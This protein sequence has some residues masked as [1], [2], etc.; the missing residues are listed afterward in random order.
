MAPASQALTAALDEVTFRPAHAPV[1]A[2]VDA[3]L[4]TDGHDWSALCARQLVSPVRWHATLPTLVTGLGSTRFT[5]FGPGRSLA[6]LARRAFPDVPAEP[7]VGLR[8]AVV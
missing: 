7:V 6:G 2:N 4:H 3:G 5:D 8:L 1:V